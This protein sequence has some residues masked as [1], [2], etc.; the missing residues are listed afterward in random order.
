M[1][2]R[3]L[4]ALLL[5]PLLALLLATTALFVAAFRTG[6]NPPGD[7]H[8]WARWDS[9]YYTAIADHGYYT[10]PCTTNDLPPHARVTGE[11][12]SHYLCGNITWFPFYPLAIKAVHLVTTLSL[13]HSA[14]L[15]SFVS[16]YLVL[17]LVWAFLQPS[18][19]P[20]TRWLCLFLA[21]FFP[22]HV[23]YATVFPISLLLAGVLGAL[24]FAVRRP[25]WPASGVAGVIA[26]ASYPSGAVLAPSVVV[27]ALLGRL[28]GRAWAP[29]AGA[30]G[31]ALAGFVG[32]L[33]YA[34]VSVGRWNAYFL[35]QKR[36]GVG[37]NNPFATLDDRLRPLWSPVSASLP[38]FRDVT[39]RQ[40]LLVIALVVLALVATLAVRELRAVTAEQWLLLTTGGA[41]WV[42]PFVAGGFVSAYRAES[43]ALPLVVLLRQLPWWAVAPALAAA[44][45]VAWQMDPLFFTGVL[46]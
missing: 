1:T 46:H 31:G 42:F 6:D 21:A 9:G 18:R 28:R 7:V 25:S 23:Y 34:Q 40:S 45:A 35:G 12:V 33:V 44:V 38:A 29:V 22:G 8:S 14:L 13:L 4:A 43:V 3:S 11:P 15:V 24:W 20:A 39:A 36:Y 26:G 41:M 19:G 30:A 27:G 2:R 16:W 10:R 32:V 5:P 37:L 17:L